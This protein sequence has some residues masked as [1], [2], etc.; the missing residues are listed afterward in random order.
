M[1][2]VQGILDLEYMLDNLKNLYIIVFHYLQGPTGNISISLQFFSDSLRLHAVL[3]KAEITPYL[4][5]IGMC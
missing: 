3:M 2:V 4:A 1:C 5:I